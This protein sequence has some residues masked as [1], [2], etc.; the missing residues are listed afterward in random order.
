[1]EKSK[2]TLQVIFHLVFHFIFQ[3][4]VSTSVLYT[5]VDDKTAIQWYEF[6]REVCDGK[7][8]KDKAPLGVSEYDIQIDESL[9]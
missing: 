6:C 2:L 1:M 4:P 8:L 5:G 9:L 7:I 3:A